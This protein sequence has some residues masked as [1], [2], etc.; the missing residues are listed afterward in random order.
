[1]LSPGLVSYQVS[2]FAAPC[3]PAS[4][5]LPSIVIG[6]AARWMRVTCCDGGA[7]A[8]KSGQT[9]DSSRKTASEFLI[10]TCRRPPREKVSAT[11]VF[12]VSH[13]SFRSLWRRGH[14]SVAGMLLSRYPPPAH[15]NRELPRSRS[16]H[17]AHHEN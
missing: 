14:E 1:M 3:H 8:A 16:H 17:F 7:S 10:D 5:S 11:N 9:G 6:P 4:S 15:L 13:E 12:V 2:N